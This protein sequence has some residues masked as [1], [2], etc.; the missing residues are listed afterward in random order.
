MWS[1]LTQA[2]NGEICYFHPS[3]WSLS[4]PVI[5]TAT[6]N[7]KIIWNYEIYHR[8]YTPLISGL[9]HPKTPIWHMRLRYQRDS[10]LYHKKSARVPTNKMGHL[11]SI[12]FSEN[13]P[14]TAYAD[15]S[16]GVRGLNFGLSLHL[17]PVLCMRA[18]K[19]LTSLHICAGL[20]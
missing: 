9:W 11:V 7:W 19:A 18:A 3:S 10:L 13:P 4:P 17:R 16:S 6:E 1:V 15:A 14:L 5:I 20:P 8:F 12:T 2:E